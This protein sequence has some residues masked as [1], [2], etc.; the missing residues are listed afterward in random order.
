MNEQAI[1]ISGGS[2]DL[3][4][5][6]HYLKQTFSLIVAADSGVHAAYTLGLC[7]DVLIGD[8]DSAKPEKLKRYQRYLDEK[9]HP[10]RMQTLP[11]HKDVSDTEAALIWVLE[12][13]QEYQ[14]D[15]I[16][17]IGA[18]GTRFDH[19]LAN[20]HSLCQALK[21]QIP[22]CIVDKHNRMYVI[23]SKA[24]C[25]ISKS[26]QYGDYISLFPLT[27]VA[28][29]VSA[30]GFAYP[31]EKQDLYMGCSLGLSNE[32]VED[33]GKLSVQ[34]GILAVIESKD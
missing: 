11:T 26:S 21:K 33:E 28:K 17:L 15:G 34:E 23:D 22:A 14:L 6:K 10:Y 20:I 4:W 9:K 31:L 7:A 19:T 12:N 8:F 2:I 25:V 27:S 13:A 1:I 30:T 5:A 32:L 24:Q 18:T 16:V 29:G 3:E